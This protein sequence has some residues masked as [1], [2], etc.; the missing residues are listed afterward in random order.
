MFEG[1]ATVVAAERREFLGV[2]SAFWKERPKIFTRRRA[3]VSK[4]REA[5]VTFFGVPVAGPTKA[6]PWFIVIQVS[7]ES[8]Q[9]RI[10]AFSAIRSG[11]A[12]VF[13]QQ[14]QILAHPDRAAVLE[15][16]SVSNLPVASD[17]A[18]RQEFALGGEEVLASCFRLTEEPWSVVVFQPTRSLFKAVR[19]L[20]NQSLF[21]I[22]VSLALAVGVAVFFARGI[23]QPVGELARGA[24]AIGAGALDTTI[25]VRARDEIGLLAESFNAMGG[26]LKTSRAEIERQNEEIR[27]WNEELQA[28]V[29]A[30]TRELR[31][32]QDQLLQSQKLAAVG[33]LGAGVA[34]EINNPLA[35]VLGL[36]QLLL[37]RTKPEE[38]A[39]RSLKSIERESLKIRDIVA[40]LLRFSQEQA[41]AG[42]AHVEAN[43]VLDD[44]LTMVQ[45]QL[46]A[47]NIEIVR[48][49]GEG[50]PKIVGD[51]SALQQ[52]VLH[53]ISNAKNAMPKGGKLT[54]TTDAL[55][56]KVVNLRIGDTGRGIAK[57]NLERIFE[58]FF[59]TKDEWSGKGL[60]LSVAF[61]IVN[62]HKGKISVVSEVGKGSTFTITLP[63]VA[64]GTQLV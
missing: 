59:T 16:R 8:L 53:I 50:L 37:L 34:H 18:E 47:Q 46:M 13:N 4:A 57:E 30:R 3:I 56:D 60:G 20:R 2:A 54:L 63:A 36:T 7:L 41:G 48:A 25:P 1:H 39:H 23:S 5:P 62:E 35:G 45:N 61:R 44:A 49:Y 9:N 58:P 6:S 14:K 28:R 31:E 19:D 11:G 27:Q 17:C 52:A 43:Q 12:F 29:D 51:S 33:E 21:W 42:A 10:L 38:A 24:R 15:S 32:A 22:A 26:A 40:N 55:E 64:R